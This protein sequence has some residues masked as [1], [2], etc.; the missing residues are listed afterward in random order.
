M[1]LR[2]TGGAEL[3]ELSSNRQQSV[4]VQCEAENVV[5]PEKK[6]MA[7]RLW[8]STDQRSLK[9]HDGIRRTV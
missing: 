6:T 2:V 9:V 5:Q 1:K 8:R 4:N 7:E 3:E